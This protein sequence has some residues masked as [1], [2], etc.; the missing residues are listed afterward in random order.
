MDVVCEE[1][2]QEGKDTLGNLLVAGWVQKN[3][4]TLSKRGWLCPSCVMT[5]PKM[6]AAS[7]PPRGKP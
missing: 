2:K 3:E 7:P 5:I 4:G 6:P 1:C